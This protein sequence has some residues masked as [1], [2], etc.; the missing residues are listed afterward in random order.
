MLTTASSARFRQI[1]ANRSG[2]IAANRAARMPEFITVASGTPL[3]APAT[4]NDA[5]VRHADGSFVKP[6]DALWRG[7]HNN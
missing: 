4:C 7:D 5:T 3:D 2:P 6:P 1:P